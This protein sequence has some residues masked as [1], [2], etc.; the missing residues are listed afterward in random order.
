MR[1]RT[2]LKRKA[3]ISLGL[4]GLVLWPRLA[5]A[6]DTMEDRAQS[7][8]AYYVAIVSIS[9]VCR[10]DLDDTIVK[11]I[12]ENITSL[13]PT[14]KFNDKDMDDVITTTTDGMLKE[15]DHYCGPGIEAFYKNI[16][17]FEKAAMV[18]ADGT[19]VTLKPLPDLVTPAKPPASADKPKTP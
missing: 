15:K 4:A 3:A 17:A 1:F 10:Y 14:A 18:A 11:A 8:I 16:P 7:S 19:G 9:K 13:M 5:F 6:V 2:G 12:V